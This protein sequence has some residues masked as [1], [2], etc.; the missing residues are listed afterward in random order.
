MHIAAARLRAP[1]SWRLRHLVAIV[2]API[3]LGLVSLVLVAFRDP[4]SRF[5]ARRSHLVRVDEGR[6]E[7]MG[8][9]VVESVRLR[10]ASG[11]VVDLLIK[12][13]NLVVGASAPNREAVRRPALLLLGGHVTGREAVHLIPATRGTV[14]AAMSYPY[15]GEHRLK[16]LQ[17]VRHV[18]AIRGAV[19][20]TP[21]AAMLALDYLS[22]R[23]DVDPRRMEGVGVSL[24]APFMVI[25]GA[26][27]ARLTRVWLLYGSGG[28]YGPLAANLEHTIRFAPARATVAALASLLISGPR[29]APERW[30]GRIAPRPFVMLNARD[31]EQMP[32]AFVERLYESAREPKSI[33]WVPGGHVRARPDIVRPL[34]DTV[35]ARVIATP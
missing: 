17:I 3:G 22:S 11:L 18:P 30:V 13:P 16:G 32:R 1:R 26:L 15:R 5:L 23:P 27:D 9:H 24:G 6:P 20:D 35:L 12:R 29:L 28:S 21:P 25:A 2:L 33:I 8:D 4:T 31:D 34:V 14:V 7:V 19:L 10:A